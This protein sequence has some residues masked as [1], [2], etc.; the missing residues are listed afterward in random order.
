M[1]I[2][3]DALKSGFN[4]FADLRQTGN[5]VKKTIISFQKLLLP[6]QHPCC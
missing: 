5:N 6:V 3:T 1:L 2:I 4:Y